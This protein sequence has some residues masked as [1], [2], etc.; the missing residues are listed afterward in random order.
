MRDTVGVAIGVAIGVAVL[1]APIVAGIAGIGANDA[2]RVL[3][4]TAQME[5]LATKLEHA[6]KIAP[7][8]K[9]EIARL[10]RLPWYD[11]KQIACRASLEARNRAARIRL[12]T[13]LASSGPTELSAHA[14]A[15][16]THK[17]N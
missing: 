16:S 1:A 6:K 15:E 11:C 12:E 7:E 17:Q 5:Q 9:L 14:K 3:E 4:A 2:R 13:I 10:T 8:T